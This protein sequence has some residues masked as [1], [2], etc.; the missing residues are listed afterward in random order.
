M[1]VSRM[2]RIV[3]TMSHFG[4]YAVTMDGRLLA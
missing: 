4:S 1:L 3:V 2:I